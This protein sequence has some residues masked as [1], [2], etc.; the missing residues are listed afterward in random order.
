MDAKGRLQHLLGKRRL[1]CK[2]RLGDLRGPGVLAVESGYGNGGLIAHV[3][4]EVDEAAGENK[5]V[6]GVE[7]LLEEDVGGGDEAHEELALDN[8]EDLGSAGVDVGGVEAPFGSE[9]DASHGEALGVESREG[10]GRGELHG[11]TKL[12]G[13]VAGVAEEGGTEVCGR[14]LG[15]VLAKQAVEG[16]IG[17]LAGGECHT[18]VLERVRVRSHGQGCKARKQQEQGGAGHCGVIAGGGGEGRHGDIDELASC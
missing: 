15:G 14:D 13:G 3:E 8:E 10:E 17:V 4:L 6:A 9:V 5:E 16:D 1:G 7:G 11:G 18:E 12:V 2:E